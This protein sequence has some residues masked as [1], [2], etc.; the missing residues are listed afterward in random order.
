MNTEGGSGRGGAG[1]QGFSEIG[2]VCQVRIHIRIRILAAESLRIRSAWSL[3]GAM[4]VLRAVF[5]AIAL[6]LALCSCRDPKTPRH[7]NAAT[8]SSPRPEPQPEPQTSNPKPQT[9]NPKP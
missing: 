1:Y 5:F 4:A 8:P 3:P 6:S 9:P 7:H 2:L